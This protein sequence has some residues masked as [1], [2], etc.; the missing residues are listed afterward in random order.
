M[1]HQL[2]KARMCE[3]SPREKG[4]QGP[5]AQERQRE[6]G[7]GA[8]GPHAQERQRERRERGRKAHAKEKEW[9]QSPRCRTRR[10]SVT[11]RRP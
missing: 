6:G 5:H 8:Q 7:G 9:D 3:Q 11:E 1:R 10:V 4:V 2:C